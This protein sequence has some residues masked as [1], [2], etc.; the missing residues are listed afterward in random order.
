MDSVTT[1][2]TLRPGDTLYV[3]GIGRA[4]IELPDS[5]FDQ[6]TSFVAILDDD[7]W[8]YL[9]FTADAHDQLAR[10]G[11]RA[12]YEASLAYEQWLDGDLGDGICLAG[13]RVVPP[14]SPKKDDADLIIDPGLAFGT[15]A[16]PTTER[17]AALLAR[18][19]QDTDLPKTVMDLGCGT[20]L[21]SLVALK[22]GFDSA[23]GCDVSGHAIDVAERNAA[24]NGLA[25]R[26]CFEKTPAR[27]LEGR[28]AVILANLPPVA[29]MELFE[30]PAFASARFAI[31]SGM[32]ASHA[33]KLVAS[34][35]DGVVVHEV[36]AD[37]P[38]RTA[39]VS[40]R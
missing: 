4:P 16:H 1:P 26:T 25:H 13:V 35:P 39:T 15:G 32:L 24:R 18:G 31:V 19:A 38:W 27:S 23:L 29:L 14:W 21:L 33:Q 30:S 9:V 8:S 12:D 7:P 11:L 36:F 10:L 2:S 37:G 6:L 34:P 17:C 3:Y 40:A 22:L 5:S 20:G 28:A